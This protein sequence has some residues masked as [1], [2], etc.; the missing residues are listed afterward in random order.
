MA[1]RLLLFIFSC[2]LLISCGGMRHVSLSVQ[3]PPRIDVGS[4]INTLV[5]LNRVPQNKGSDIEGIMTGERKNQDVLNTNQC[6]DGLSSILNSSKRFE[7][8]KYPEQYPNSNTAIYTFGSAL[9]WEQVDE[10][11]MQSEADAIISVE[12]FDSDFSIRNGTAR[13][14]DSALLG[15]SF[16]ARGEATAKAGV[17]VYDRI[18]RKIVYED[19]FTSTRNWEASARTIPEAIK[20]VVS[21]DEAFKQVSYD[22]GT[23]FGRNLSPSY[24][25]E[26]RYYFK[27]K[28]GSMGKGDRLAYINNFEDAL[29][30][31]EMA[32]EDAQKE[33]DKGKAAYNVALGYEIQGNL[34]EAKKW[35]TIAYADYRN[36]KAR[37]YARTIQQRI[38]QQTQLKN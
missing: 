11:C 17:R 12:F 30:A 14:D 26:S 23:R 3:R 13:A 31:W 10:I 20:L 9:T 6:L 27:G 21:R 19:N 35:I 18:N 7:Y 8:Q 34:E 16:W 25:R 2:F 37:D 36:K 33:K 4:H 29:K 15:I 28:H 1:Y 32:F 22:L 38:N 24:F 5:L